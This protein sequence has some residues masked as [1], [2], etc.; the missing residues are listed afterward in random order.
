MWL[1]INKHLVAEYSNFADPT[2]ILCVRMELNQPSS[3][4]NAMAIVT[5]VQAF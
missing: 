2:K 3:G 5:T 1:Y 4:S